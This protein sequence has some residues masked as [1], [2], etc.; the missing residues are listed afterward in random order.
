MSKTFAEVPG[1]MESDVVMIAHQHCD[2][3][4]YTVSVDSDYGITIETSFMGISST[5]VNLSDVDIDGLI[6]VLSRA[7]ERIEQ[8]KI[9]DKLK[10]RK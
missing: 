6:D 2:N 9:V 5:T 7:K 4:G 3:G 8:L 10:G 1:I